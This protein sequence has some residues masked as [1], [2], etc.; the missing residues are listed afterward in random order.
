VRDVACVTT[1]SRRCGAT[2]HRQPSFMAISAGMTL[3]AMGFEEVNG[4]FLER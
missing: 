2:Q 1:R 4:D 3:A